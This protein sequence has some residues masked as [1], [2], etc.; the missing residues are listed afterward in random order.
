M[1]SR[2]A[3]EQKKIE[4]SM[5]GGGSAGDQEDGLGGSGGEAEMERLMEMGEQ[6]M[7]EAQVRGRG[8]GLTYGEAE[9]W[10]CECLQM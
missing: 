9:K 1:Q 3:A 10:F 6:T 5:G 8:R 4:D 2:M 7:R